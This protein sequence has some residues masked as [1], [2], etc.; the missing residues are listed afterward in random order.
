MQTKWTHLQKFWQLFY[1]LIIRNDVNMKRKLLYI[2]F[3]FC[4]NSIF[5]KTVVLKYCFYSN[6]G[7][8]PYF[9][10]L[11]GFIN[12]ENIYFIYSNYNEKYKNHVSIDPNKIYTLGEVK[13]LN[14]KKYNCQLYFFSF[15]S[16]ICHYILDERDLEQ[17]G[18]SR[19]NLIFSYADRKS[20]V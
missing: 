4:L 18:F 8:S 5:C 11:V 15:K 19:S 2:I 1:I 13:L 6:S 20:V 9:N 16:K 3:I 10:S 14:K 12:E 7:Y 17:F